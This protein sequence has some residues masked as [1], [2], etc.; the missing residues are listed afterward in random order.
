MHQL[1]IKT[2]VFYGVTIGSVLLLFKVVT[3]YGESN[4]K[5]PPAINGRYKLVLSKSLPICEKSDD[6][7]LDVQQSGI[8]VNGLLLPINSK[9][10]AAKANTSKPT[11]TGKFENQQLSLTGKVPKTILCNS[12]NSQAQANTHLQNNS[13]N[14]VNTQIQLF[15]KEHFT[16]Q[17][18]LD[19][20]DK[21][22]AFTA[23]PQKVQNVKE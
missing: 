8:Y 19:V 11:L 23:T 14:L 7:I 22:I 20:T 10:K 16:G 15:N 12:S 1:K 21:S 9:E 17:I 4:L 18:N 13:S 5:A 3:A 2:L 6:L